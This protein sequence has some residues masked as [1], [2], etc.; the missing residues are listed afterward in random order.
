MRYP[1]DELLA[2]V[3]LEAHR[4]GAIVI[5]EDLG[6]VEPAMREALAARGILSY[7]LLIFEGTDVSRYPQLALAAVS[8][9]DLPTLAGAWTGADLEQQRRAGLDADPEAIER[10]RRP[11]AELSTGSDVRDAIL[12]VHRRL[13]DSP[14]A[15]VVATLEDALAVTERPN[16]PG[17]TAQRA[18]NWSVALPRGLEQLEADPFVRQLAAALRRSPAP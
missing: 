14:A 7:R 4:A 11:L 9:H 1:S 17:T 12:A 2:I 3:A 18:P 6:T 5:G 13:A 16:L 10:L 8:T 15:L